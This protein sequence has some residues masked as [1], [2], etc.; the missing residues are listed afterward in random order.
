MDVLVCCFE[1]FIVGLVDVI[2]FIVVFGSVFM[3]GIL[4]DVVFFISKVGFGGVIGFV[5]MDGIVVLVGVDGI[6]V[7]VSII[8][9]FGVGVVGA[10]W[11]V[12]TVRIVCTVGLVGFFVV[13]EMVCLVCFVGSVDWVGI[14][15][16]LYLEL[17]FFFV[18]VFDGF[19]YNFILFRIESIIFVILWLFIML[20]KV[21]F[22]VLVTLAM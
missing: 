15:L 14:D 1:L 20:F 16:F 7:L 18:W 13:V 10:D 9:V 21:M 8:G 17:L 22:D 4:V 12:G 5:G 2:C 19:I 6:V 3:V 11:L